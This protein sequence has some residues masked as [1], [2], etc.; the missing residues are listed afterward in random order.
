M[1]GRILLSDVKR[2]NSAEDLKYKSYLLIRFF[3]AFLNRFDLETA[4]K[5][6]A[7]RAL[8]KLDKVEW[9]SAL[10]ALLQT[11]NKTVEA[12]SPQKTSAQNE[13][14]T[15]PQR[16]SIIEEIGH[17]S[18]QLVVKNQQLQVDKERLEEN[19]ATLIEDRQNIQKKLDELTEQVLNV[20]KE[21]AIL[22][23]DYADLQN[24]YNSEKESN[25]LL[26]NGS[27]PLEEIQGIEKN[28]LAE[29]ERAVD[30]E[31]VKADEV[32]VELQRAADDLE[33][34]LKKNEQLNKE[35]T[36]L[37]QEVLDIGLKHSELDKS[38]SLM[39]CELEEKTELIQQR[40]EKFLEN[41]AK[42]KAL[43][44]KSGLNERKTFI[45]KKK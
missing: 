31:R 34:E 39:K 24:K 21:N 44:T 1:K 33:I 2:I 6:I 16:K 36:R 43:N 22:K 32:K 41:E 12:R 27:K 10:T 23:S 40:N 38:A 29:L 3:Y 14:S 25:Q 45:C 7:F 37:Q 11:H 4:N 35:V 20:S 9:I 42:L 15:K 18:E 13:E 26:L 5:K 30:I 28:K 17:A 19:I 8:S